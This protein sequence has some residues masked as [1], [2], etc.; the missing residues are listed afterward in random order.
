[1]FIDSCFWRGCAS[2]LTMPKNNYEFWEQKLRR[3]REQDVENTRQL[4]AEGWR[5][6][7]IWENEIEAS[8]VEC[9]QWVAAML[10]KTE[11]SRA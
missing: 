4:E 2:H 1:M 11:R 7:R 6:L 9:A 8:S 3:D 10:G 5:V